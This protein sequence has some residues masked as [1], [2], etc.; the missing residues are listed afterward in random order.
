MSAKV[1][2]GAAALAMAMVE[3]ASA[4]VIDVPAAAIVFAVL[5]VAGWWWLRRSDSIWPA[6]LLAV[7]FVIEVVFVPTYERDSAAEWVVQVA[8]L[9]VGVIG[10]AAL[11]AW[12]L[13]RR[14]EG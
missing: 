9:V 11:V 7:L 14:A 2:A 4:F 3:I 13:R 6:A 5:F 1:L 12:F 8:A 10:L